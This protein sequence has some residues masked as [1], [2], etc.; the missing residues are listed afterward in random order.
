MTPAISSTDP[1]ESIRDVMAI[2]STGQFRGLYHVLGGVISPV[3]GIGPETLNID[4]LIQRASDGEIKE[5]I[6]GL[7]PTDDSDNLV[8]VR[9]ALFL[10]D[11]LTNKAAHLVDS[12]GLAA[13]DAGSLTGHAQHIWNKER[14]NLTKLFLDMRAA[15]DIQSLR[16][17]FKP[18]S[19]EI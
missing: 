16:T 1:A 4:A 9:R 10:R 13:I 11:I 7:N 15:K 3:D 12:T 6:M 14:T 5:L 18:F 8:V 2:E 19:E 17:E